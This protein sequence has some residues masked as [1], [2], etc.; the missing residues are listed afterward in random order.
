[1][2]WILI[3]MLAAASVIIFAVLFDQY[4]PI[5]SPSGV[6]TLI[7]AGLTFAVLLLAAVVATHIHYR[8]TSEHLGELI[9]Q[10]EEHARIEKET[11]DIILS[12]NKVVSS[13]ADEEHRLNKELRGL[14]LETVR[15]LIATLEARDE[16]TQNHSLRVAG[17][18]TL[19]ARYVGV[20]ERDIETLERAALLHDIGKLG[21]PD[22][23]L[24]KPGQ[25]TADEFAVVME[26][27]E[28][29]EAIVKNIR[30]LSPTRG[31]VRH[32]H[33]RI[34]GKGY[35]DKL[36]DLPKLVKIICIADCF[37]AMTSNRPYRPSMPYSVAKEKMLE[38][39]GAQLDKELVKEF[40]ELLET[41]AEG[42]RSIYHVEDIPEPSYDDENEKRLEARESADEIP[43]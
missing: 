40:F 18:S 15:G 33:E 34:D 19:L 35:P 38:V 14:F 39:A 11:G 5:G 27:P 6:I 42:Y 16:Y 10:A 4:T 28:R 32:H 8:R 12:L 9:G 3:L 13:Q 7:A 30:M 26:H 17:W 37:D 43:A 36:T 1:M 29:G 24:L 2:A 23:I 21:L 31:V 22:E 25:L 41:T 20:G